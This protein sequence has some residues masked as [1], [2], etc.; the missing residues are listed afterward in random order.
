VAGLWEAAVW[1]ACAAAA[2][3]SVWGVTV[4]GLLNYYRGSM[5]AL[6]SAA[7]HAT[8]YAMFVF[9]ALPGITMTVLACRRSSV[10]RALASASGTIIAFGFAW[11]NSEL[12]AMLFTAALSGLT[13]H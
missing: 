9:P 13:R 2:Y 8:F 5:A 11:Q 4:V 12:L 7:Q 6:P 10:L 3:L 1:L